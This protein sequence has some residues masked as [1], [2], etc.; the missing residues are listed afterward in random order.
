MNDFRVGIGQDS[1][2]LVSNPGKKLVVGGVELE[3]KKSFEGTS[4]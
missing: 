4:D 1:H 3:N 2:K